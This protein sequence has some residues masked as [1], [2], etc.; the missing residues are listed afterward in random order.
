MGELNARLHRLNAASQIGN[1]SA[2]NLLGKMK[3]GLLKLQPL[4]FLIG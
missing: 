1:A 4:K 3:K 2:K